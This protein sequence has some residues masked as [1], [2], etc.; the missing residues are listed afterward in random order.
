MKSIITTGILAASLAFSGNAAMRRRANSQSARRRAESPA[1]SR[2][3]LG[4]WPA[5]VAG[6]PAYGATR[7]TRSS[8]PAV[9]R[10]AG[11]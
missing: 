2:H 5:P 8:P 4:T 9:M 10:R 3:S 7:P 11:D 6:A 1:P